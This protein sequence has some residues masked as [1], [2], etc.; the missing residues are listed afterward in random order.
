MFDLLEISIAL[1]LLA[2]FLVNWNAILY[3]SLRIPYY[4]L[5]QIDVE[6]HFLILFT[7]IVLLIV[8]LVWYFLNK[9]KIKRLSYCDFMPV[10]E[11][12][13][14]KKEWTTAAMMELVQN[15]KYIFWKEKLEREEEDNKR[16]EILSKRSSFNEDLN[17]HSE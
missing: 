2:I 3:Y 7:I 4:F 13:R 6:I 12:E 11:Y 16:R 10:D 5:E 14:K 17:S 15:P 1:T 8:T 9:D